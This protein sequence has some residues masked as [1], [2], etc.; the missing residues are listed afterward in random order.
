MIKKVKI[1][2]A[3]DKYRML[4]YSNPLPMW[5]WENSTGKFL[6]VNDAAVEHYGYTRDEFMKMKVTQIRPI[7]DIPLFT[8]FN[9]D[10]AIFQRRKGSW[11]HIK[12]D[13]TLIDVE[14]FSDKIE[15]EGKEARLVLINDIT[16]KKKKEEQLILSN[17]ILERIGSLVV[18]ANFLGKII[19]ASKS[20]KNI[21]GFK[22]EDVL[23]DKWWKLTCYDEQEREAE[24]EYIIQ[25]ANGNIPPR[26]E[27][28]EKAI[29]D[30]NGNMHYILW[31]ETLGP[32]GLVIGIGHDITQRKIAED[33][34]Y[35]AKQFTQSILSNIHDVIYSLDGDMNY[36]FISPNCIELTGYDKNEFLSDASLVKKCIYAEDIDLVNQ[37]L[38]EIHEGKDGYRSEFRIVTKSGKVKWVVNKGKAFLI[39]KKLV[40]IDGSITDITES[41]EAKNKL[42]DS[43]KKYRNLI[44]KAGEGIFT[45]DFNGNFTYVNPKCELLTEY[46]ANELIGKNF[47]IL[48][49]EDRTK[50]VMGF[51]RS[52]FEG[53]KKETTFEFPI[54]TKSGNIKWVSQTAI[55]NIIDKRVHSFICIIHDIT[56][57]KLL[58]DQLIQKNKELDTFIY[59]ASHDLKGP[60][61]SVIG[62][63][64]LAKDEIKDPTALEYFRMVEQSTSRL[65]NI[66]LNLIQITKISRGAVEKTS[67]QFKNFVENILS[68][69]S[70]IKGFD[71]MDFQLNI[72]QLK[73][74]MTDEK[75]FLSI[76]QNLI[77][78]II[79]YRKE[80]TKNCFG[81]I[82]FTEISNGVKIILSDNGI[83]IGAEHLPK[84]YE[85]F[86]RATTNSMGS[87]LGLF[88]VKTAVDKL[89]GRIE[90]ESKEKSGTTFTLF[91]PKE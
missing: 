90:L 34:L 54:I 75:I 39:N 77:E 51:Y 71:E 67:I 83:G 72:Q 33:E 62:L 22:P 63:T 45:S 65:N 46:K 59:K 6:A 73:P 21:L 55:M 35:K 88:I 42:E 66:L 58:S 84:V 1:Q 11:K 70:N 31:H 81:K 24:K 20:I 79:K 30:K 74:F 78:N 76:M 23:G 60:L 43:E 52:Q 61:A 19:Y 85:M 16:D 17:Q 50:K 41:K 87:G 8:K 49:P 5:V 37:Y 86:Y 47:T 53:R 32:K 82:K 7:E 38:K 56:E 4:F 44:E 80:G 91:F 40:R 29:K 28:Y 3:D 36:T 89:G 69:L 68:S 25:C 15:F 13:G 57:K 18:V 48:I 26:T 10:T 27:Q 2:S 9:Q 12:K 64:N 14:F